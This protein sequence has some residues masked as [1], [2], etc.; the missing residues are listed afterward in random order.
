M[1]NLYLLFLVVLLSILNSVAQNDSIY[2]DNKYL[3]DQIYLGLTYDVL[4]NKPTDFN[5]NGFS[6]GLTVGFIKDIP[7]NKARNIAIGIGVGY[8]YNAFIQNLLISDASPT[9]YQI[10]GSDSYKTNRFLTHSI[11]VPIEFRWRTSTPTNYKFWRIYGGAKIGFVFENR[12][13]YSGDLGLLKN[14]GM[15]DFQKLQYGLMLSTGY[16][17]LNLHVYYG[18]NSLF[19][20]AMV[21]GK[22]LDLKQLNVGF[23]FYIL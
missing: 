14:T 5:Q 4:R 13:K 19:K 1:K 15:Q 17:T 12:S 18:L 10:V 11:E 22:K 7:L 6:G 23:I 8:A 9:T 20:N 2:K 16:N 3:E 21:D